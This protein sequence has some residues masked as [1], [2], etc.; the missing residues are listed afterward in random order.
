MQYIVTE[1]LTVKK[2]LTFSLI[3]AYADKKKAAAAAAEVYKDY[4]KNASF[5]NIE[6]ITEW[7]ATRQNYSFRKDKDH[8]LQLA[9]TPLEGEV[10]PEE[11]QL[12]FSAAAEEE[13]LM[14]RVSQALFEGK[15]TAER[16]PKAQTH[17]C[18]LES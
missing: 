1:L 5:Q 11:K 16:G 7:L 9:I 8:R 17:S 4:N 13:E 12:V 6:M 3:G 18:P 2:E 10:Q 15:H 14:R